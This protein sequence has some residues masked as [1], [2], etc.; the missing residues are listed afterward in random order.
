MA[1]CQP[2]ATY[3]ANANANTV[4]ETAHRKRHLFLKRISGGFDWDGSGCISRKWERRDQAHKFQ[5]LVSLTQKD[6]AYLLMMVSFW[7]RRGRVSYVGP[8][9]DV[10]VVE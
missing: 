7:G 4:G 3:L 5:G 9:V 2:E 8:G 10:K 6:E 1:L